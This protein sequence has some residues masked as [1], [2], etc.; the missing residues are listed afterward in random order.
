MHVR[1]LALRLLGLVVVLGLL[2]PG[3][4]QAAAKDWT[5]SGWRYGVETNNTITIRGCDGTCDPNLVIP[6]SLGGPH[7]S[8]PVTA[9][10]FSA[11]ESTELR[12]VTLP[13]S[14]TTIGDRAFYK[15][16][17][18][19]VS[20]PGGVTTIGESA[21]EYFADGR[22]GPLQ[23]V[24]LGRSITSIGFGAFRGQSLTAVTLPTS[25]TTIGNQAFAFNKLTAIEFPSAV[26][27]VGNAAFAGNRLSS[28]TFQGNAPA[29]GG[30]VFY[31]N[32]SMSVVLR[33]LL[34]T[35][36]SAK[37]DGIAVKIMNKRAYE[38]VGPTVQGTHAVGSILTAAK[39][40][41]IGYPAPTFKYQWYSCQFRF[42]I[43]QAVVPAHCAKISAAT[44]TT[45]TL[46]A[47]QRGR[48]IAV[49][50]TAQ[51]AGTPATVR[52]SAAAF[53]VR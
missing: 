32:N 6:S 48:Y 40:T 16:P 3:S 4:A 47:A 26:T 36:W 2:T 45:L 11:C 12:S 37:W 7:P 19:T 53:Q 18:T 41:W 50:V 9:I 17:L 13:T 28:A 52:L 21:F 25:L 5:A 31:N 27:S 38:T 22:N 29:S 44:S 35:G 46:K 15:V 8:Y 10:R 49:L 23:T 33:D 30:G 20:I 24:A 1:H 34:A 42:Q 14:L 39:G 51:S 43:P